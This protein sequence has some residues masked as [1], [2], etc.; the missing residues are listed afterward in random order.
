MRRPGFRASGNIQAGS[1]P[2]RIMKNGRSIRYHRLAII[3]SV[4]FQPPTAKHFLD[5]IKN[6]LVESQFT[7]QHSR[8]HLAGDIVVGWTETS[9]NQNDIGSGK[10]LLQYR[11]DFVPVRNRGLPLNPNTQLKQLLAEK[12]QVGVDHLPQE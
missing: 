10:G 12:T 11:P 7:I 5:R 3:R 6:R 4:L 9:C 8:N 1:C 2:V